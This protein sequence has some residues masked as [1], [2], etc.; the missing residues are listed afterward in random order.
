V[1]DTVCE[2]AAGPGRHPRTA[3]A[4]QFLETHI[5]DLEALQALMGH[6]RIET[7]QVCLR[8]LDREKAMD[9]VR[10]LSWGSSRFE[11]TEEEAP[12]GVEPVYWVLQTHA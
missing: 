8:R 11:A 2:R 4:V 5:G 1:R 9:R 12:T 3:F 10:D 7:T 6:K